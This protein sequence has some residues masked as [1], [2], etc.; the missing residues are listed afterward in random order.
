MVIP[1][2]DRGWAK[3]KPS[4]H[5]PLKSSLGSDPIVSRKMAQSLK[6]RQGMATN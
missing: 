6:I 5:L 2:V 1:L 4:W 3:M